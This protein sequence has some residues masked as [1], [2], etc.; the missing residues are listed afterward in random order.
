MNENF[1][2]AQHGLNLRRE[3]LYT[4]GLNAIAAAFLDDQRAQTLREE[5][6]AYFL[7]NSR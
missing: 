2:A 6:D 1:I 3:D 5:L 7:I 4:I